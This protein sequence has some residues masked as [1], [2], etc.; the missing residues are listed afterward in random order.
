MTPS[1]TCAVH[2]SVQTQQCTDTFTYAAMIKKIRYWWQW[3]PNAHLPTSCGDPNWG[4]P[5]GPLAVGLQIVS[6]GKELFQ[7][8]ADSEVFFNYRYSVDRCPTLLP[9]APRYTATKNASHGEL[10]GLKSEVPKAGTQR[11]YP[12]SSLL[13]LPSGDDSCANIRHSLARRLCADTPRGH[14]PP[15]PVLVS[16][17]PVRVAR[18]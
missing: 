17:L 9:E 5:V 10:L 16:L 13:V 2:P 15:S 7:S 8:K 6:R 14:F 1:F 3:D 11:P 18:S 12:R 4:A